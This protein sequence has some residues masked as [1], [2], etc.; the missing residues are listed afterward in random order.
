MAKDLKANYFGV[1]TEQWNAMSEAERWAANQR[2]LDAAI[3][4]GDTFRLATPI[5]KVNPS[6]YTDKE[7]RY[8]MGKGYQLGAD[9]TSLVPPAGR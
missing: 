2:F 5:E 6:G 8:L 4:R 1:P 7:I 3:T 9:R